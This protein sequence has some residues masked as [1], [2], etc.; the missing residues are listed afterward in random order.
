MSTSHKNENAAGAGKLRERALESV[1]VVFSVIISFLCIEAGYRAYLFYTFAFK[2]DYPVVVVDAPPPRIDF[3]Y[4]GNVFGTQPTGAK[5]NAFYYDGRNQLV[6]EHKVRTNN[7]GWTSRYDY[8]VVKAP[9]EYRIA[10]IG[11]STTAAVTNEIAWTDVAQD[12]LNV[13]KQLLGALRVERISVL[14]ISAAGADVNLLAVPIAVIA[15]RFSPDM[16]VANLSIDNVEMAKMNDFAVPANIRELVSAAPLQ[17]RPEKRM[18][19]VTT[20]N[21]TIP[22]YCRG[23]N[24]SLSNP[25]C[26]VSPVWHIARGTRL[27]SADLAIVKRTIARRRLLHTV[28]LSPRPLALLRALG[29]A[30]IPQASA[31]TLTDLQQ[32]RF[33]EALKALQ[34]IHGM[35][36]NLLITHNPQIWHR[37]SDQAALID[38]FIQQISAGGFDIVRMTDYMPAALVSKEAASWY[39]FNGHWND[40][41]AEVYGE[42]IYRVLRQRLLAQA[43]EDSA[44]SASFARYESGRRALAS[45]DQGSAAAELDAAI[46][47]LPTDNAQRSKEGGIPYRDC[48]FVS[49]LHVQRAELYEASADKRAA[50]AQWVEAVASTRDLIALYERRAARRVAKDD[51]KGAIEDFDELVRLVPDS[52]AY[53]V[54]R[55]D[56]RLKVQDASGALADFNAASQA[57]GTS[58]SLR[59]RMTQARWPLEDYSGVIDDATAGLAE[60]PGNSGLLFM[61][62]AAHQKLHQLSAAL[63]DIS[64]AI[65]SDPKNDSLQPVRANILA[66]MKQPTE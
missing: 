7:L 36:P 54:S 59:F 15:S 41:G 49:D 30:V 32:H 2:A 37:N 43:Q 45:G 33:T 10:V 34:F 5:Y 56:L 29:H 51:L 58:A 47:A 1:L 27:S 26:T 23:D 4:P 40:H 44:C 11:G 12:R 22:L 55:G 53:Y 62:S 46:A 28:L 50:D 35:H 14:N 52:A 8:S 21:V 60:L 66:Q 38:D 65:E 24:Q 31:A 20:N 48:G 17:S 25:A 61:R 18:S 13:D 39:M 64:A 9:H 57:G 3:G 42:A 16:M 63:E 19:L 6:Y